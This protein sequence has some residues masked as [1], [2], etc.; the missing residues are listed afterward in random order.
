MDIQ[1]GSLSKFANPLGAV[2]RWLN[3]G[4]HVWQTYYGELLG[5]II[6][7]N[8]PAFVNLIWS[9]AKLFIPERLQ[10]RCV[11]LFFRLGV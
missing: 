4:V 7:V 10:V 6:L 2:H 5:K 1:G 8:S 3:A 11:V 9:V